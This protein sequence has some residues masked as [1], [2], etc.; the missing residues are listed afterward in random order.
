MYET[1]KT[2]NFGRTKTRIKFTN[3][4]VSKQKLDFDHSVCIA[5]IVL[6]I[7]V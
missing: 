1:R 7:V 2:V 4:K 5:A 6:D 3:N